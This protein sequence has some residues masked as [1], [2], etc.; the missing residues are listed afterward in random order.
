MDYEYKKNKFFPISQIAGLYGNFD[1]DSTNDYVFR[2]GTQLPSNTSSRSLFA[3]AMS[4]RVLQNETVFRYS[5]SN[6]KPWGYYNNESL[7]FVPIFL[8]EIKGNTTAINMTLF[9]G[10]F[11]FYQEANATCFSAQYDDTYYQCLVDV[12]YSGSLAAGNDS[13]SQTASISNSQ[14]Q[15]A[16]AGPSISDAPDSVN[17]RWIRDNRL[18]FLVT[19]SHTFNVT[20]FG[21]SITNQVTNSSNSTSSN[22]SSSVTISNDIP[23]VLSSSTSGNVTNVTLSWAPS[24]L[25]ITGFTVTVT[26]SLGATD[27][28]APVTYYCTCINSATVCLY[29]NA[30]STS[31]ISSLNSTNSTTNTSASFKYILFV[32][33]DQ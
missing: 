12:A 25:N 21:A 13:K 30:S 26:D 19:S 27:S 18:S 24:T 23:S 33:R 6:A 10:D 1:G 29:P 31:A 5:E 7:Y 11:A 22:S 3:F 28:W 16:N 14:E 2:N 8:D 17:I 32:Y 9:G 15:L 4:W 20:V